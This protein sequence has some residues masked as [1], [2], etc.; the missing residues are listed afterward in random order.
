MERDR[1]KSMGIVRAE[2]KQD[3]NENNQA[4]DDDGITATFEMSFGEGQAAS[5]AK[6]VKKFSNSD[7]AESIAEFLRA[8]DPSR[9]NWISSHLWKENRRQSQNWTGASTI[10][11]DVD[12][13]DDAGT[14]FPLPDEVKTLVED[15]L[16]AGEFN[17]NLAY[18]TPRGFRLISVMGER[19]TCKKTYKRTFEKFCQSTDNVLTKLGVGAENSAGLKVDVN[20]GDLARCMIS[21]V[22]RVSGEAKSR[23]SDVLTMSNQLFNWESPVEHQPK[24]VAGEPTI[25]MRDDGS[26]WEAIKIDPLQTLVT[27]YGLDRN[28]IA[29]QKTRTGSIM[30]N[31]LLVATVSEQLGVDQLKITREL[32]SIERALFEASDG[33]RS[34]SEQIVDIGK[35]LCLF[36]DPSGSGYAL[37]KVNERSE[38]IPIGSESFKNY[39]SGEYFRLT[40]KTTP[41]QSLNEAVRTLGHMAKQRGMVR[42]VHRRI[43]RVDDYIYIDLANDDGSVIEC[44]SDGWRLTRDARSCFLRSSYMKELPKP[45]K[46]RGLSD[47]LATLLHADEAGIKLATLSVMAATNAKG[48]YPLTFIAGSQG[49]AKST[50]GR[51]LKNILDPEQADAISP[52]KNGQ[53]LLIIAKE[54]NITLI[55]NVSSISLEM[56][57]AYCRLATGGAMRG[58]KLY[59]NDES[60]VLE[61]CCPVIMTGISSNAI[62][63]DDLRDRCIF[64]ELK[65]I[66]PGERVAEKDYW[67]SFEKL[68]PELL[69]S[70]CDGIVSALKNEKNVQ[71][72]DLPRMADSLKWATAAEEGLGLE[73]GTFLG[74]YQDMIS[75]ERGQAASES[76]FVATID[77]F[78]KSKNEFVGTATELLNQIQLSLSNVAVDFPKSP[79]QFGPRL[80]RETELLRAKG[81]EVDRLPRG[82]KGERLIKLSRVTEMA[83]SGTSDCQKGL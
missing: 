33:K 35:E 31:I 8:Q 11:I 4:R 42:A 19:T 46:G 61:A 30:S 43:A 3:N 27:L 54:S 72:N 48:P 69:G 15:A 26:F 44:T 68:H 50:A 59:T 37:V 56:S 23:Q 47:L 22:A 76:E 58:R 36:N 5:H 18:F 52:P 16:K 28:V 70:V 45:T 39:L 32:A 13:E 49:S 57:D 1:S 67:E 63:Q 66:A 78:L 71:I 2:T 82:P 79:N 75:D 21:P 38:T 62:K 51:T 83:L 74:A 53:D 55:D 25:F 20:T 6:G 10:I 60:A 29:S 9:H 40:N 17:A 80:T 34:V 77:Q 73:T 24:P 12:Y 64:F 41:D 14:H 81:I 7:P 65:P